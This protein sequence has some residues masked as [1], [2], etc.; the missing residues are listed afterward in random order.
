MEAESTASRAAAS[1]LTAEM[2]TSRQLRAELA[3]VRAE[4]ARAAEEAAVDARAAEL[5]AAARATKEAVAATE[6]AAARAR[7]AAAASP[8]PEPEPAAEPAA[9][10]VE[11]VVS[12]APPSAQ[13]DVLDAMALTMDPSLVE[14]AIAEAAAVEAAAAAKLE[15]VVSAALS[16]RSADQVTRDLKTAA[17][18]GDAPAVTDILSTTGV[19]LEADLGGDGRTALWVAASSGHTEVVEVLARAGAN[20]DPVC[21]QTSFTALHSAVGSQAPSRCSWLLGLV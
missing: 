5:R 11:R 3:A 10:V 14:V 7:A 13:Q 6:A 19:D 1:A 8:P 2:E 20:L 21:A 16:P 12:E 9:V 15:E 17:A 18:N 4:A